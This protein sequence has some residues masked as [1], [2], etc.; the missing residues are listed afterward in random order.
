MIHYFMKEKKKV[1][2]FKVN[3]G[4]Q[5][6]FTNTSIMIHLEQFTG[7][8]MFNV[9]N[10]TIRIT[11]FKMKDIQSELSFLFFA[12]ISFFPNHYSNYLISFQTYYPLC[13]YLLFSNLIIHI[14]NIDDNIK[15]KLHVSSFSSCAPYTDCP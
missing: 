7:I 15:K 6:Q 14:M 1:R 11:S 13:Q 10:Q 5:Y 3:I 8:Y 12:M 9:T 2:D 4:L